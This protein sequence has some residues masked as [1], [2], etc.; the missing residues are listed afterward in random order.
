MRSE[1]CWRLAIKVSN[2][3][4]RTLQFWQYLYGRACFKSDM[5]VAMC[6]GKSGDLEGLLPRRLSMPV[7]LCMSCWWPCSATGPFL[8]WRLIG[9][10]YRQ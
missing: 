6:T 7:R 9:K 1:S 3:M 2:A 10:H 5:T 4:P 8:A